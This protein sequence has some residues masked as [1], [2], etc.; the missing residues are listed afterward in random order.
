VVT[1]LVL[2]AAVRPL[3]PL[4]DAL[5]LGEIPGAGLRLPPAYVATAPFGNVLDTLSLLSV[6]QH[7][8]VMVTVGVVY[9][10]WRVLRGHRRTT[11]WRRAGVEAGGLALLLAGLLAVYAALA[12]L[13]RPMAALALAD[14]DE[15]AVDFH[16]HT[17]ASHDGRAGWTPETVRAWLRAGGY[18]AAYVTDHRRF[19]GA[20]AAVAG[21]PRRAGEGTSMFSGI[22]V[23]SD[24]VHLNVLGATLQDSAWFRNKTLDPDSIAAFIPADA[25]RPVVLLTIPANLKRIV[26]AMNLHA[27]EIV[28]AAPRGLG[29][30]Q[31]KRAEILRMAD[32]LRLA[33]AAASDNHGWGRTAVGWTLLRVPGWRA[34][35]PS[36]LDHHIRAEILARREAATRVAERRRFDPADSWLG[37]AGTVPEFGWL[38]LRVLSWP[39]RAAWIA[40]AWGIWAVAALARRARRG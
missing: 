40:W 9:A 22:E 37:V 7:V 8:A 31:R 17:N 19:E 27:V 34:M 38:M 33:L 36:A 3:S 30:T 2:L 26:P 16:V 13:P 29:E 24:R 6:A 18:D 5:T 20:A 25:S 4:R 35:L 21:N 12:L 14:P 32:T 10:L 23:I 15:V 28:D 39:E 1:T 11:A